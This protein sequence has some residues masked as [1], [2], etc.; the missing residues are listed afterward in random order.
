M[1]QCILLVSLDNSS[2][3]R[4]Y[5]ALKSC[6]GQATKSFFALLQRFLG[7]FSLSDITGNTEDCIYFVGISFQGNQV[8]ILPC[9]LISKTYQIFSVDCISCLKGYI[10][11]ALLD[12]GN[13]GREEARSG[14]PYNLLRKKS[15]AP[16]SGVINI[17]NQVIPSNDIDKIIGVL[18]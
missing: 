5:Y 13:F 4:K 3:L 11:P 10:Q 1:H 6:L 8:S 7:P 9:L 17:L 14:F 15:K 18:Y 2:I 12:I 16:G